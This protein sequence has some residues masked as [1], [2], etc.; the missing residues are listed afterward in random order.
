MQVVRSKPIVTTKGKTPNDFNKLCKENKENLENCKRFKNHEKWPYIG[1][2]WYEFV[3]QSLRMKN[4][5]Q[6]FW[7]K[8]PELGNSAYD[9]CTLKY[10]VIS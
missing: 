6:N 3:L 5:L 10:I 1:F 8:C 2:P 4:G 7:T 9:V